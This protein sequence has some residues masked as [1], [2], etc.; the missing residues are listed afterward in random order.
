MAKNRYAE[1]K[2]LL[3]AAEKDFAAFYEKSNKAA[4]TRVRKSMQEFAKKAKDIRTEVQTLK[5]KEKEKAAKATKPAKPAA[6]A[7]AKK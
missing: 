2:S 4:G 6:K 3:E 1:L 5:N 7:K